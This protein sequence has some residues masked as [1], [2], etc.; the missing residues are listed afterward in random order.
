MRESGENGK[1]G[2]N[3][4]KIFHYGKNYTN[5]GSKM[6][7]FEH[8]DNKKVSIHNFNL[9]YSKFELTYS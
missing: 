3:G 2:K 6:M 4:K 7:I 1:N 8:N 5:N 9:T